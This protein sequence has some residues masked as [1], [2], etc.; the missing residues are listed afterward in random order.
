MGNAGNITAYWMGYKE[1]CAPFESITAGELSGEGAES[2]PRDASHL[3]VKAITEA[4]HRLGSG[5]KACGSRRTTST[6]T[7]R[8]LGSSAR[9]VVAAVTAA[10]ALVPEASRRAGTGSCS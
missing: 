7:A 9:A 6:R 2:L 3:V 1:Y 10:N 8:G 5:T 4:L